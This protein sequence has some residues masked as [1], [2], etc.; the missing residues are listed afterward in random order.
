MG[1]DD[2]KEQEI[3][4]GQPTDVKH[5]SHIGCDGPADESPSWVPI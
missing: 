1:A 3:Q 5:V 2:E 4:I